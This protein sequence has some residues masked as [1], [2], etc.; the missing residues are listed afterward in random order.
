MGI[1]G[2]TLTLAKE[3]DRKN[4]KL[5]CVAPNAMTDM[6]TGIIPPDF[7]KTVGVKEITPVVVFLAH[8]S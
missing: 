8:E 3:G 5:N 1:V 2:F 4:I 6:T 7:A